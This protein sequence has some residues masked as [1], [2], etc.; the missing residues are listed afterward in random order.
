[1]A[2]DRDGL[3]SSCTKIGGRVIAIWG[4]VVLAMN[5]PIQL[6]VPKVIRVDKILATAVL[7]LTNVLWWIV[8]G[9]GEFVLKTIP[10]TGEM[11]CRT[12]RRQ[13]VIYF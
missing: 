6:P 4:G 9:Q 3:C 12:K 13:R 2:R 7:S 5:G 11:R 1:M 8:N 10:S